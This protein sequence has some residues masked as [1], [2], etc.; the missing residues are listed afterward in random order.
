MKLFADMSSANKSSKLL[1]LPK[2]IPFFGI[3]IFSLPI[4]KQTIKR[5][6]FKKCLNKKIVLLAVSL[7]L[8]N[9]EELIKLSLK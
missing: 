2:R 6:Y 9:N 5:T 1:E 3:F 8:G 4:L 7:G